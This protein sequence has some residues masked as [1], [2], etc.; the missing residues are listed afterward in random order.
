MLVKDLIFVDPEDDTRVS[1]VINIFG[2]SLN[3]VWPD[4]KLG[5]ILRELKTGRSHMALVRDVNNEDENQDP[6]YEI[7]GIITLEDIIE[8]ILGDEIVDETDAFMDGTHMEPVTRTNVFEWARLRLLDSKLVDE[9]LSGEETMAITAHLQRNHY[10]TVEHLSDRQVELLVSGSHVVTLPEV[11][12]EIGQP[13]PRDLMYSKNA[14]TDVCTLVLSGKVT[15]FVGEEKFRT[16]LGSW[17]VLGIGAL[18]NPVYKPDFDAFV[19][20]GPCRCIRI[21]RERFNAA[22]DAS[23]AERQAAKNIPGA[24]QEENGPN[25]ASTNSSLAETNS[26]VGTKEMP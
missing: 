13:L 8:E 14:E 12:R 1:D 21:S 18:T 7:K 11:V 19:S 10:N 5:D 2:R 26:I 24:S 6:F 15:V 16:D 9:K 22:V 20:S 17:S 25:V 4:D 3:T 23:M